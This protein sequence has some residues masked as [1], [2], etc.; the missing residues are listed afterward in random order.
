V[1]ERL[2]FDESLDVQMGLIKAVCNNTIKGGS[3]QTRR[4][5]ILSAIKRINQIADN[6]TTAAEFLNE[7]TSEIGRSKPDSG[8]LPSGPKISLSNDIPKSQLI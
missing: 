4:D 6:L 1:L 7:A 8:S 2:V 3:S 5:D